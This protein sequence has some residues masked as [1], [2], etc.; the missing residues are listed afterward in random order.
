MVQLLNPQ[1]EKNY[2]LSSISSI[3]EKRQQNIV[4]AIVATIA[5]DSLPADI[6]D[7]TVVFHPAA[8]VSNVLNIRYVIIS[9]YSYVHVKP[10]LGKVIKR[11]ATSYSWAAF[12][13]LVRKN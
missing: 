6:P 8:C 4:S 10:N 7:D 1:S 13:S 2:F 9:S 11:R 12:L 5:E 3:A